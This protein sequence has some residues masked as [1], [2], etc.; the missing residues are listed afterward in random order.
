MG[1]IIESTELDIVGGA[2]DGG[3]IRVEAVKVAPGNENTRQ[4]RK[5]E[6]RWIGVALEYGRLHSAGQ[7]PKDVYR[8]A[9][10]A[11]EVLYLATKGLSKPDHLIICAQAGDEI[12]GA[13]V[14][15]IQ[16]THGKLDLMAI[17]P[18]YLAG[19]PGPKIRGIGTLV[20]RSIGAKF[21]EAG[22]THVD[23]QALDEAASR[24]WQGRGFHDGVTGGVFL[25]L[26]G[27][28]DVAGL[29]VRC[30]HEKPDKEDEGDDVSIGDF[31]RNLHMRIPRLQDA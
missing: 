13:S 21:V 11:G 15:K 27:A 16:G 31:A 25:H 26:E 12:L 23:L 9:V 19:A 5:E 3:K 10:F 18:R 7:L 4:M 17:D 29:A 20:T 2:H 8:R 1:E 28:K 14:S 22:V 30:G 6:Q 24:F